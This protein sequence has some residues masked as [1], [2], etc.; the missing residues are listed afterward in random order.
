MYTRIKCTNYEYDRDDRLIQERHI[1]EGG[2]IQNEITYTYDAAGNQISVTDVNGNRYEH[3]YDLNDRE[4]AVTVPDGG[5]TRMMYDKNGN[6][7]C[8]YTPMQT[9]SCWK[10]SYDLNNR[11]TEVITPEGTMLN[12]F[13]YETDG[14]LKGTKDVTGS[15]IYLTYDLA[16]RRIFAQ[17]SAGSGQSYS[18]DAVGNIV[19]LTDG[20]AHHTEFLLDSWGRVK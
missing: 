3:E 17:I 18:Y 4:V 10:Y 20:L 19:G 6:M 11:M 5:R 2:E 8:R 16:G 1:E 15:G 7:V 12:R 13:S 14:Q 9:V